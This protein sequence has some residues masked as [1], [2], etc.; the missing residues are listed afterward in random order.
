MTTAK[1]THAKYLQSGVFAKF[2]FAEIYE[3]ESE[4]DGQP[5][6]D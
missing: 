4:P 2:S 5:L 1:V 6:A 3:S